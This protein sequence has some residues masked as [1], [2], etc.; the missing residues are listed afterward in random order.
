M[1]ANDNA[2][3]KKP[4]MCPMVG[5]YD[6]RQLARTGV[7]VAVSTIFGKHADFRIT[8][9]LVT[10]SQDDNI[11]SLCLHLLPGILQKRRFFLTWRTPRGPEIQ[12]NRFAFNIRE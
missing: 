8:E 2:A 12:D 11:F 4:S 5:W 3:D 1:D 7:D 10:P 9:A 6:P